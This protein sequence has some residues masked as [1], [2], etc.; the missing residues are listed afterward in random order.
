ME[1]STHSSDL[2][3]WMRA[4][5]LFNKAL[6]LPTQQRVEFLQRECK[7][8]APLQVEVEAL[9]AADAAA[10]SFLSDPWI[11]P[12][13]RAMTL[14]PGD[15]VSN[16]FKIIRGLGSGGMGNIYEALD[17]ELGVQVALK[18]LRPEV[19]NNPEV[20][21]RFRREVRIAHR[22]T[23]PNVCRTFHLDREMRKL[24][25]GFAGT[26]SLFFLTMEYL[27]GETLQ[28][29][30]RSCGKLDPAQAMKFAFQMAS[31]IEAAHKVGAVHRD[32]KPSNIMICPEVG[33][34]SSDERLVI[35]DFGLAR[36]E[37]GDGDVSSISRPGSAMGTLSYMSPEQLLGLPVGPETDIYSFGLVLFEMVTGVKA[38]P[39]SS[40]LSSASTR[41]HVDPPSVAAIEPSLPVIWDRAIKSCLQTKAEDRPKHVTD[42]VSM[43]AGTLSVPDASPLDT[44]R[45][46]D[47]K[48]LIGSRAFLGGLALLVTSVSLLGIAKRLYQVQEGESVHSGTLVY[49]APIRNETK[50][51]RLDNV[52]DLLQ[53]GLMQ[54][55]RINL[56]DPGKA[57]DLLTQMTKSPDT[58]ID[59]QT[60]REIAMRASATRVIFVDVTGAKGYYRLHINVEQPDNTPARPRNRWEK[61]WDWQFTDRET[62]DVTIPSDLLRAVRESSGWIRHI[63]GESA[64]DIAR[65]DAPAEEVTTD[66]WQALAEYS[67][68]QRLAAR[69][70]GEGA[71]L[72]LQRA[73]QL[74]PKFAL[75]YASLGDVL[76][77][78]NRGS[79]SFRAYSKALD[80]NLTYRLTRKERD[81][82]KG[83]YAN[84]T[85]DYVAGEAAFRD[86]SIYYENDY[87][88]MFFRA[89]PLRMLGRYRESIEVLQRA[90]RL[91]PSSGGP[92]IGLAYN[93]MLLGDGGSTREE[94]R[95]L[96]T[97][98]RIDEVFLLEG[99][100]AFLEGR[101]EDAAKS[102]DG[103][104]NAS[105]FAHQ[106]SHTS[107]LARL[108]A[109]RG[110]IPK[111]IKLLTMG[112][113]EDRIRG[114]KSQESAHRLDRAT[115]ECE[116]HDLLQCVKDTDL[117]VDLDP[118]PEHL[119]E[120]S[121]LLGRG[122]ARNRR[123]SR[124]ELSI[125]LKSI[126]K[127]L[128]SLDQGILFDTARLRIQGEVFLMEGKVDAALKSFRG[129]DT[130]ESPITGRE[131]LGRAL[132]QAASVTLDETKRK[133][134]LEEAASAYSRTA[135]H[136]EVV[137]YYALD[138]S[139]GYLGESMRDYLDIADRLSPQRPEMETIHK[140]LAVL[141]SSRH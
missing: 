44:K 65:L 60:A 13:E 101:Y 74:D 59:A 76:L 28:E 10:S 138:Y 92:H 127:K 46:K 18:T 29:R 124:S 37:S 131:Y 85:R 72:A 141:R 112:L 14:V 9:L 120:A 16:R 63:V 96:K 20:L 79:E 109:E 99:H 122:A 19:A 118:R 15:V 57:G 66:N 2:S 80:S 49:L 100:L 133:A 78:I 77:S 125:T 103:L 4:K 40:A 54:S 94:I 105:T 56:L 31:A 83:S 102:F 5:E 73:V 117:A 50:E 21:M 86:E 24:G 108:A 68:A 25:D 140:S 116:S 137:W 75:A 51:R 81:F 3:Q 107:L 106:A 113:E 35:T 11:S 95:E 30:L 115:L 69:R 38:F 58:V 62:S 48:P 70:D 1:D 47:K 42:V 110:D 23:H 123:A 89:L 53:S 119:I 139:P 87:N 128:S 12:T 8:D 84:D 97:L 98:G 129:A 26:V 61:T 104:R 43:L 41:L 132:N 90:H 7:G 17:Y 64:N 33:H 88:A 6:D 114:D 34:T 55:S 39:N 52:Y 82:I 91:S 22:I 130:L 45:L 93:F 126:Q 111:A 121:A 136:P 134:L 135:L 71:V 27:P 36:I 32:I 67:Q